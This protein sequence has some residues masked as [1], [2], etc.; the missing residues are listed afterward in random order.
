MPGKQRD[1]ER[2][3]NNFDFI[4]LVLAS[5]VILSH[6]PELRD[7]NRSRELL[8]RVF[9]T[10]S[11]GELGVDGF[12]LL[13]GYLIV[14]S[15][16][17]QPD[18]KRFV[19]KRILRIYPGF[20]GA[21]LICAFIIGPLGSNA[22]HYF[23]D[24]DFARFFTGAILLHPTGVPRVSEFFP[25]VNGAMWTIS[26][27]FRCYMIVAVLGFS[28]IFKDRRMGFVFLGLAVFFSLNPGAVAFFSFPGSY[29]LT[30]TNPLQLISFMVFFSSGGIYYLFRNCIP[31][32]LIYALAASI[33]LAFCLFYARAAPSAVAIFGGYILFYIG[34]SKNKIFKYVRPTRDISYGVYLYGW[35]VEKLFL[36]WFPLISPWLLFVLTLGGSF[37]C[38]LM[39]WGF[40]ESPFLGFRRKINQSDSCAAQGDEHGQP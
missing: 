16:L 23:R 1:D 34:Y 40:I 37:M 10:L 9:H 17:R 31:F 20:I 4:R 35:P 2:R 32:R 39:S 12:F 11:F 5:L 30:G 14:A 7:G 8:T 38:G 28:R 21:S 13:S 26:Y 6:S 29:L 3:E 33:L 36:W 27:E 15:W 24:F 18:L 25:N 22:S 19:A